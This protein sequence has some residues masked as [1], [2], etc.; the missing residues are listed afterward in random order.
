MN[1]ITYTGACSMMVD[2]PLLGGTEAEDKKNQAKDKRRLTRRRGSVINRAETIYVILH[3]WNDWL[4]NG[5]LYI[6][7]ACANNMIYNVVNKVYRRG[8]GKFY[9]A[10][11]TTPPYFATASSHFNMWHHLQQGFRYG[12]YLFCFRF[13][14]RDSAQHLDP[15]IVKWHGKSSTNV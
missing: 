11:C 1:G 12:K 4:S 15:Q 8:Q 5:Q 13:C 3:C 2:L 9:T 14:N 10:Y 7:N 6:V